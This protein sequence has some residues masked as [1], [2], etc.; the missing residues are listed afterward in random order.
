MKMQSF[1]VQFVPRFLCTSVIFTSLRLLNFE[2]AKSYANKNWKIFHGTC[3]CNVIRIQM[4][5]AARQ[6]QHE[7]RSSDI[8]QKREGWITSDPFQMQSREIQERPSGRL[9]LFQGTE[10]PLSYKS[11]GTPV[12]F[13]RVEWNLNLPLRNLPLSFQYYLI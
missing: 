11:V 12:N 10:Q 7:T 13:S 6:I 2:V 3:I 4:Q 8:E 1:V 5:I 9:L